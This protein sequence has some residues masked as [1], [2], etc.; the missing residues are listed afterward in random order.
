MRLHLLP[1]V[2]ASCAVLHAQDEVYPR[3]VNKEI[4]SAIQR[5]LDYI[6]R[7][8]ANDGSWRSGGMQGGYPAAMTG[9]AGMAQ[10]GRAH[11]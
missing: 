7:N 5:G 4:Q 6:A 3:G 8:Q 11:V 2:L 1:L 9:L 10:I